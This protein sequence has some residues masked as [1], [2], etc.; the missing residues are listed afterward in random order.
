MVVVG[1]TIELADVPAHNGKINSMFAVRTSVV[2]A[3]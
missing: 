2:S 3:L 1:V